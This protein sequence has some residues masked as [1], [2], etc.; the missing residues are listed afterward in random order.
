MLPLSLLHNTPR[1]RLQQTRFTISWPQT[2]RCRAGAGRG[3]VKGTL[4]VCTLHA[5]AL[6]RAL[7]RARAWHQ[8]SYWAGPAR[9][10]PKSGCG[11]AAE[12]PAASC[13]LLAAAPPAPPL[14]RAA[15]CGP[16]H[17][18]PLVVGQEPCRD[19]LSSTPSVRRLKNRTAS[20]AEVEE[21]G[22]MLWGGCQADVSPVSHPTTRAPWPAAERAPAH[23]R[24]PCAASP[25]GPPWRTRCTPPPASARGAP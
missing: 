24:L 2:C 4:C 11:A 19:P 7:P 16:A 21:Q 1:K 5:R 14:L 23:Q 9:V 10:R 12:P 20:R 25:P 15:P 8:L 17:L 18:V 13:A 3:L 22:G 6:Q